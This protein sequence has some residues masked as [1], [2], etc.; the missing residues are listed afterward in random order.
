ML[1]RLLSKRKLIGEMSG[2]KWLIYGSHLLRKIIADSHCFRY[3]A[4]GI[5]HMCHGDSKIGM[6]ICNFLNCLHLFLSEMTP[7]CNSG[8][9]E[10][11]APSPPCDIDQNLPICS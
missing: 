3:F 11:I 8:G 4:E 9:A 10:S 2:L 7:L 5:S 6:D 1:E